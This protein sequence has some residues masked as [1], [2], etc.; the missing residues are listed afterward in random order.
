MTQ[1]RSQEYFVTRGFRL[2]DPTHY[3]RTTG[4]AHQQVWQAG[5]GAW[6]AHVRTPQVLG[7]LCRGRDPIAVFVQ[8]ELMS[9]T[10]D[11]QGQI[12]SSCVWVGE[13]I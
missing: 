7:F 1:Q 2:A 3:E 5:N 6:Y 10:P 9:W 8:A 12:A 11:V 4:E 13:P